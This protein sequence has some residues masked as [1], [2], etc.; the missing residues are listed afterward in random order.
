M[1]QRV[2]AGKKASGDGTLPLRSSFSSSSHPSVRQPRP[3]MGDNPMESVGES[4]ERPKRVRIGQGEPSAEGPIGST[5]RIQPS[6]GDWQPVTLTRDR[7]HGE[8][9]SYGSSRPTLGSSGQPTAQQRGVTV[10]SHDQ[11]ARDVVMHPPESNIP[12]TSAG[13][14]INMTTMSRPPRLRSKCHLDV[15]RVIDIRSVGQPNA[16]TDL[17]CE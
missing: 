15:G 10:S 17:R 6:S 9:S 11:Q 14:H 8:S 5:L 3:G 13:M 1:A 7:G 4:A 2:E 16:T 12:E